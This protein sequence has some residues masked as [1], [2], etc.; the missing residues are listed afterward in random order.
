LSQP[1]NLWQTQATARRDALPL[2]NVSLFAREHYSGCLLGSLPGQVLPRQCHAH[3]R[4]VLDV[5]AGTVT[6]WVDSVPRELGPGACVCV[7]AG[8]EHVV[9]NTGPERWVAR[10]TIHPRTYRRQPLKRAIPKRLERA[11][12]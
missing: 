12:R 11:H 9:E 5:T 3:E 10:A 6:V 7:P 4:E 2:T 1:A 8:V